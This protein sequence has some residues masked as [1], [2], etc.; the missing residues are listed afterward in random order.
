MKDLIT[1]LLSKN[2]EF[3]KEIINFRN[4]LYHISLGGLEEGIRKYL[5]TIIDNTS[6]LHLFR[7]SLE[8]YLLKEKN[9][10]YKDALI[11]D[12]KAKIYPLI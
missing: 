3:Y 9:I 11:N 10:Y 8:E 4:N 7:R 5:P 2:L 6:N 12:L 1:D